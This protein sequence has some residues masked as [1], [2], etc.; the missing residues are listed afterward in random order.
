MK[1]MAMRSVVFDSKY[2]KESTVCSLI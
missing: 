1:T 2:S